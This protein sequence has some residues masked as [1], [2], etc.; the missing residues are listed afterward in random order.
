MSD[1]NGIQSGFKQSEK[2]SG[3]TNVKPV[4]LSVLF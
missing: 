1:Q 3:A 2:W 4:I